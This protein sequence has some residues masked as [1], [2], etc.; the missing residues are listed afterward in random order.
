MDGR[1]LAA[2]MSSCVWVHED[3]VGYAI[4]QITQKPWWWRGHSGAGACACVDPAEE[5]AITI[6]QLC[7]AA[8]EELVYLIAE[9]LLQVLSEPG[10]GGHADAAALCRPRHLRM[11]KACVSI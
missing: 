10:M 1:G 9:E 3:R 2:G 11:W 8:L 4:N 6:Y 7:D 5:V